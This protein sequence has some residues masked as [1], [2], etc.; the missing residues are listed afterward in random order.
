AIELCF[1][2]SSILSHDVFANV[3]R[4]H[5]CEAG[6]RRTKREEIASSLN[7]ASEDA[8]NPTVRVRKI[9]CSNSGGRAGAHGGDPRAVRN[10]DWDSGRRI[11][12]YEKPRDIRQPFA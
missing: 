9:F 6:K 8:R 10:H 4:M 1:G 11:I 3:V 7:A 12:E 2:P 5:Q